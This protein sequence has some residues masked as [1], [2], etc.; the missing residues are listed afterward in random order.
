MFGLNPGDTLLLLADTERGIALVNPAE[1]AQLM[2]KLLGGP[3]PDGGRRAMSSQVVLVNVGL[4]VAGLVVVS[5]VR[6][7]ITV[8]STK[9]YF[10]KHVRV[11]ESVGFRERRIHI[12]DGL[13]LNVA[14]GPGDGI[15]LLMIPGQGSSWQEYAKA[16][17]PPDRHLPGPGRRRARSWPQ[18]LEPGGLLGGADR[19]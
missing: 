14:E 16:L 2:D 3:P 9:D 15:P 12:R 17:P 11:A 13:E 8:V 10:T 6:V 4:A 19:R 1:H 7:L 5:G 18:H